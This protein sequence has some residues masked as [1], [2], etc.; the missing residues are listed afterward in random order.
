MIHGAELVPMSA[1]SFSVEYCIHDSTI[2][3][4]MACHAPWMRAVHTDTNKDGS[5]ILQ[6]QLGIILSQSGHKHVADMSHF[7]DFC[8][9]NMGN[10]RTKIFYT[11]ERE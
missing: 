2:R 1:T 10:L 4:L 9:K 3:Q 7:V 8:I 5:A 6:L 11:F